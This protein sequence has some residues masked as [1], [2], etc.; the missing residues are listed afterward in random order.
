MTLHY[1][2]SIVGLL[3]A[4][5]GASHGCASIIKG[6][7]QK[8]SISSNPAGAKV[9]VVPAGLTVSAPT[10]VTVPC[11]KVQ[12]LHF[13]LE[14]HEPKDAYLGRQVS[15]AFYGNAVIGGIVGMMMDLDSGAAWELVPDSVHV[16]L[17]PNA[18][19]KRE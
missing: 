9:T 18:P 3:V 16:T 12:T 8:L 14:G 13:E 5:T 19:E 10:M 4:L 1:R 11:D 15:S 6:T 2:L 7:T 17:E